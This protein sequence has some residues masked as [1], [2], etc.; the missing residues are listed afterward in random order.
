MPVYIPTNDDVGRSPFLHALP[1]FLF[2]DALKTSILTS[3][4]YHLIVLLLTRFLNHQTFQSNHLSLAKLSEA[5]QSAWGGGWEAGMRGMGSGN[6]PDGGRN[7][8]GGEAQ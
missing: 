6:E 2:V 4:R 3:V 1:A 7:T 8:D 5:L